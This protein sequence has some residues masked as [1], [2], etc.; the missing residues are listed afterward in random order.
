MPPQPPAPPV[1]YSFDDNS[2]LVDSLANFVVKAQNDAID[3][4]GKFTL[5]LSGGSLPNNLKGLVGQQGVHWEKWEVFFCDERV[6]PLDHEDSNF[7]ACNEAFLKHVPIPREQI[8]TIDESLLDDL[9]ELSDQYEKQLIALFAEKNAARFPVFD[10]ILLGMGPDGH[11]CSLFPGHELLS[12]TD[13]WVAWLD[14]SPKPPSKRIT[15]TY[16]VINHA[17]RCAFVIAGESKQDTLHAI[18]DEPEQ[19]LPCS[20]VRPAAPGLVFW[21]ADAAAAKKTNYPMTEF[22]WIDSTAEALEAAKMAHE[23]KKS[24]I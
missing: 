10:L 24:A 2:K 14:D 18:L 3:K 21:F 13:R 4:R 23:A 7:R 1:F 9:D 11:T 15:F 19:G 12:E 20:R 17:Y 8:H 16:P 6:V 5:A 22:K